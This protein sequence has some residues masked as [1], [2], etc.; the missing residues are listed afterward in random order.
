MRGN[1]CPALVIKNPEGI[2]IRALTLDFYAVRDAVKFLLS[3]TEQLV[4]RM[5]VGYLILP[6]P[7]P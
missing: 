6:A 3:R 5:E 2:I 1:F 4:N 7:D